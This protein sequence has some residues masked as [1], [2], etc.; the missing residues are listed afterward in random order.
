MKK[1][2][3]LT[4]QIELGVM[5]VVALWAVGGICVGGLLWYQSVNTLRTLAPNDMA[6]MFSLRDQDGR[7]HSLSDYHDRAVAM[8]FLPNLDSDSVTQLRSINHT[9]RQF[10]TL[11]V[12]VFAIAPTDSSTAQRIH[13]EEHLEFPILIDS[14]GS[15]SQQYGVSKQSSRISYVIGRDSRVILPITTVNIADHGTQ[16]SE[17]TECCLDAKPQPASKLIGKPIEDFSLPRAADNKPETLYGGNSQK[18]TVLFITSAECPCS[19]KYEGRMEDLMQSYQARGVRFVSVNASYGETP[20]QISEHA[21]ATRFSI[22]ILKDEGNVI[23]DRIEAQVTPEAFVMDNHH[24]L[25][26]HGRIDDSRDPRMV[27]NH[28]LRNA[29]DFLLAGKNPPR[30]DVNTFGCAI[31]RAPKS[32]QRT[33]NNL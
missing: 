11:G 7:T 26:Y 22:P 5:L 10:D 3:T 25:R 18:L 15:V 16:M 13:S 19:A 24:V 32:A 23:A 9:I 2:R 14:G 31:L 20:Q 29:L 1:K 4:K 28:D 8:A 33:S 12:K 6:P 17:L 30:A 27:Q 21:R